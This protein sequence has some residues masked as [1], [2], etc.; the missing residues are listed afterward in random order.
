MLTG[1]SL[2]TIDSGHAHF[3]ISL[4]GGN[5]HPDEEAQSRP[6]A[7]LRHPIGPRTLPRFAYR[8]KRA[9]R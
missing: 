1:R 7:A 5:E 3:P 6:G 4:I 2:R 8:R 9:S